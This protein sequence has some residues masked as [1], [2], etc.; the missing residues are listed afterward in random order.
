MSV[1]TEHFA[2]HLEVLNDTLEMHHKKILDIGNLI[3]ESLKNGGTLYICGNG[4]SAS[5]S[6][7]MA[8]EM[9][10][11]FS[12]SRRP[13]RAVALSS[14]SSVITCIANDFQYDDIFSRQVNGLCGSNDILLAISTSGDSPNIVNALK[15]SRNLDSTSIALLG[16]SGGMSK[17][18]ADH[19]IVVP[20]HTT[21]RIQE[22]HI[23]ILHILCD[24]VESKM[25]LA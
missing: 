17:S 4:G 7:H 14:D 8:A 11:R 9:M 6:Q 22:L 23:L 18:F 5:D 3:A 16:K 19:F 1:I 21:A 2:E 25:Q 12:I 20:S 13:I 10:G 24:I 15:A